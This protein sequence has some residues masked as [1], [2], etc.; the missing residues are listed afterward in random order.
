[1]VFLMSK[2]VE[3]LLDQI[4][5][6]CQYNKTGLTNY[7][8]NRHSN[9][10]YPIYHLNITSDSMGHNIL[11]TLT[12]ETVPEKRTIKDEM[13]IIHKGT[14]IQEEFAR[15]NKFFNF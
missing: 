15:I 2:K 7:V 5:Q 12:M 4:L 6:K 8:R 3:K 11:L 1:M 9:R 13:M 10:K 14:A